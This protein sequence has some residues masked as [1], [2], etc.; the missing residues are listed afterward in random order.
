MKCINVFSFPMNG[1]SITEKKRT[2][3]IEF[4]IILTYA[5]KI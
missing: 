2:L 3:S 4:K 1:I 5:V